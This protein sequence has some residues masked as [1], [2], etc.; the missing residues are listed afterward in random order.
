V[1][2]GMTWAV[3]VCA[4]DKKRKGGCENNFLVQERVSRKKID[5]RAW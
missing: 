1:F 4:P 2:K 5:N 3:F